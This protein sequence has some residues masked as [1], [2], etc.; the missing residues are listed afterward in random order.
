MK[1]KTYDKKYSNTNLVIPSHIWNNSKIKGMQKMMLSLIK[2]LTQDGNKEIDMM[3]RQMAQIMATHLKD[4]EHNL[5]QLHKNGFIEIVS[6]PVSK[7]GYSIVY[8]YRPETTEMVSDGTS[9]LF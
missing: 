3:T 4:I 2:K 9:N 7:T 5:K 6:N 1:A 8:K